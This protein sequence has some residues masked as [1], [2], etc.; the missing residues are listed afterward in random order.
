MIPQESP[1]NRRTDTGD[2]MAGPSWRV[3][4]LAVKSQHR[5]GNEAHRRRCDRASGGSL[6]NFLLAAL[7]RPSVRLLL[8]LCSWV[9][10]YYLFLRL[11]FRCRERGKVALVSQRAHKVTGKRT[12]GVRTV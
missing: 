9:M 6:Q 12:R 7:P 2:H 10:N 3:S 5:A 8:L 4:S 1:R 11:F